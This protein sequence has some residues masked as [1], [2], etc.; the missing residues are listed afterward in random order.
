MP[1]DLSKLLVNGRI[2]DLSLLGRGRIAAL[3]ELA[4]GPPLVSLRSSGVSEL[5]LTLADRD[6]DLLR[7]GVLH[8]GALIEWAELRFQVAV[9][10]LVEVAGGAGVHLIGR[11]WTA[12]RLRRATGGRVAA[13]VS[14]TEFL[15]WLVAESGGTLVGEPTARRPQVARINRAAP[16][17]DEST[18][19][20]GVRLAG[21]L[22][23]LFF[24]AAD[25]VYF[26]RP[27]WLIKRGAPTVIRW[28]AAKAAG[29]LDHFAGLPMMRTSDDATEGA[30]GTIEVAFDDAKGIRPG[31]P[32]RYV[33]LPGFAGNYYAP[34]VTFVLDGVSPAAVELATPVDPAPSPP[35]GDERYD[36][37][38]AVIEANPPATPT[39]SSTGTGVT[40]D[41]VGGK[42]GGVS[43]EGYI[44]PCTGNVGSAFG[45]RRAPKAGASTYHQGID[46]GAGT[47]TRVHAS[48][49]GRVSRAAHAGNYGNLIVIDHGGGEE[50]RYAHLS[51]IDVKVGQNVRRGALIGAVGATGN[52]TGPH[53]HFETRRGGK[54]FDPLDVLPARPVV[55]RA[56]RAF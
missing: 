9:I 37:T 24:E 42:A 11:S 51:R 22:G 21:E 54:A 48:R 40:N 5:D 7:D 27:S 56:G 12:Q 10:E 17:P 3:A 52:V 23:F 25:V 18:W 29:E 50:T 34:A 1:A 15:R 19:D 44:W 8:K 47:G 30:T 13:N 28:P 6:L 41:V 20:T 32:F 2:E 16:E 38:G 33:G 14:P 26:G 49:S 35:T 53:L 4:V 39:S 55:R 31:D 45:P 46:I 36:E 43:A